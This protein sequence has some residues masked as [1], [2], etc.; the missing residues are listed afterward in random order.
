MTT[1]LRQMKVA[2]E[3]PGHPCRALEPSACHGDGS[4]ELAT[5]GRARHAET[6]PAF[7]GKAPLANLCNRLVVNEH[8]LDLPTLG[9]WALACSPTASCSSPPPCAL[10][11]AARIEPSTVT[12]DSR[13]RHLRPRAVTRLVPLHRWSPFCHRSPRGAPSIVL[14]QDPRWFVRPRVSRVARRPTLP[15]T[16]ASRGGCRRRVVREPRIFPAAY[17]KYAVFRIRSAFCR[18]VLR[19]AHTRLRGRSRYED[20]HWYFG[21]AASAQLPTRF[22]A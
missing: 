22:H 18:R 2:H 17:A 21:L 12:S 10:A 15:V 14:G 6:S 3:P 13:K 5:P 16:P 11:Q 8:P 7:E 20:R 9:R 4:P 1:R 19:A